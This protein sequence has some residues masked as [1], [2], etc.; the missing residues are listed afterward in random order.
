[1]TLPTLI[2]EQGNDEPLTLTVRNA[3]GGVPAE[4]P[5]S[6]LYATI[7]RRL[8]NEQVWI[9]T[10][11]DLA[12]LSPSEG[13]ILLTIPKAVTKTAMVPGRWYRLDVVVVTD[14]GATDTVYKADVCTNES[15][16]VL[17]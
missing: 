15:V 4:L 12:V 17:P 10:S 8:S 11:S 6:T 1:M 14:T 2:L 3:A 7:K 5:T 16:T 9:A 13:T